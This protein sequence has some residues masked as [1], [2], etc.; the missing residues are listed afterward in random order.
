MSNPCKR[1]F[2]DGDEIRLIDDIP[3]CPVCGYAVSDHQKSSNPSTLLEQDEPFMFGKEKITCKL[4]IRLLPSRYCKRHAPEPSSTRRVR[5][6]TE[7][8]LNRA[9]LEGQIEESEI[10]LDMIETSEGSTSQL[11]GMQQDRVGVL[12]AELSQLRGKE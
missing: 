6:Y 5:M 7:E 4:C 12:G 11:F 10:A 2:V 3:C 8:Q 1:A 9:V